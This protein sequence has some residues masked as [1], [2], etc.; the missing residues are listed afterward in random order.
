M[1]SPESKILNKI[2][3]DVEPELYPDNDTGNLRLYFELELLKSHY[4]TT[5]CPTCF[6]RYLCVLDTLIERGHQVDF[7]T[8]LKIDKSVRTVKPEEVLPEETKKVQ[9]DIHIHLDSPIETSQTSKTDAE[10]VDLEYKRTKL[11]LLKAITN[12]VNPRED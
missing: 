9:G 1:P 3:F 7:S 2:R 8:D 6:D 11:E 12:R 10:L 5:E 4:E